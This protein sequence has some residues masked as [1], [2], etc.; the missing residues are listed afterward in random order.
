VDPGDFEWDPP[1]NRA[2]LQKHGIDFADAITI[3]GGF[4]IEG[5]DE[6]FDYGEARM[7]A[8]GQMGHHVVA[9]VFCWRKD[10]RRIISARKA[11]RSEFQAYWEIVYGKK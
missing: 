7:I 8:Y 9:V 5:P 2:N 1:K 10:R 11:T 4:C 6:R 3:F